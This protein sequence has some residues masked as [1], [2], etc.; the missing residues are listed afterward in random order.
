MALIQRSNQNAVEY[1]KLL[2]ATGEFQ[3]TD[4]GIQ[5][6]KGIYDWSP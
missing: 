3:E 5:I 4:Q 1:F 2:Q 6:F